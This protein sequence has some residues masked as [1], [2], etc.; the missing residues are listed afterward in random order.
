MPAH[1][2]RVDGIDRIR[3][4]ETPAV[5]RDLRK[6]H[7][8]EEKVSEFGAQRIQIAPI[9]GLE[10]L[11]GFLE[12]ERPKRLQGLLAIPGTPPGCAQRL[13]DLHERLKPF[14]RVFRDRGFRA[15]RA[16]CSHGSC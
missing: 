3:D 1:E 15:K 8:L 7:R 4:G 13:H 11:V 6:K 16:L 9:D 10:H 12:H 2:L 5:G 14:C